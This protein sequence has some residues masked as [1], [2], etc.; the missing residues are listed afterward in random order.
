MQIGIYQIRNLKTGDCYIGGTVKK[1]FQARKT[2][3]FYLLQK[4]KHHSNALQSA[5]IKYGINDFIFEIIE[6]CLPTEVFVREQWYLDNCIC[7]YNMCPNATGKSGYH[8]S[9]ETRQKISKSQ[10]GKKLKPET[11]ERIRQSKL[12]KRVSIKTEFKPG[13][14]R[15][16]ESRQKQSITNTGRIGKARSIE[17]RQKQSQT[18]KSKQIIP[19]NK[20]LTDVYSEAAKQAMRQA[21]LGKPSNRRR[22]GHNGSK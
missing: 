13:M 14:V 2:H 20:G 5:Y 16:L 4:G 8:H 7:K 22:K 10:L 21:K 19:W 15:S 11:V 6:I 9:E 17:S 12:G 1:G 18:R 3:H